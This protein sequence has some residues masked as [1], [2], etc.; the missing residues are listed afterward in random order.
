LDEHHGFTGAADS[1][2]R[3]TLHIEAL[4]PGGR[5]FLVGLVYNQRTFNTAGNVWLMKG[6][7]REA[8]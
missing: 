5:V 4:P 3:Y 6:W 2:H 7:E 8:P 1:N